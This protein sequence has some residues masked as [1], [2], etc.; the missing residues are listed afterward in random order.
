M[1][2][3]YKIT[4]PSGK[5]Y[6]GQ[7]WNISDRIS[8]YKTIRCKTQ[9]KIY[10]SLVKYGWENHSFCIIHELPNDITQNVIDRYEIFYIEVYRN[11]GID[12]MNIRGGG[13]KGELSEETKEKLR[14]KDFSYLIGTKQSFETINKRRISLKGK[15]RSEAQRINISK[16]K[17]GVKFTE[18]P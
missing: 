5:I 13:S 18:E 12:L 4:S 10:N 3:I 11:A 6:I 7:S 2:G 16:G 1:V 15:T 8:R 9:R 14:N 17:K